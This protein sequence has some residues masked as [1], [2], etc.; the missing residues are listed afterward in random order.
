MRG[1]LRA[2]FRIT[3]KGM[4]MDLCDVDYSQSQN[5]KRVFDL[6]DPSGA[7]V[8]VCAMAHNSMSGAL[9]NRREII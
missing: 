7:Y 1:K 6:M 5:T 9:Q 4:V 8:K 2:P 3:L